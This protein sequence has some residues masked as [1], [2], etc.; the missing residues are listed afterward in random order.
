MIQL[1]KLA[2]QY[3]QK[4]YSMLDNEDFS[5]DYIDEQLSDLTDEIKVK[6]KNVGAFILNL[7][8]EHD[9]TAEAAKRMKLRADSLKKTHDSLVNYLIDNIVKTDIKEIK[10]DEF[11]IKLADCPESLVVSDE[12][13][14]PDIYLNAKIVKTLDKKAIKEAISSGENI[15]GCYIEKNKRLIIK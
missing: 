11:L 6:I 7:K 14:I 3:Q 2:N 15:P 9:A 5:L 12:R 10:C 8:A 1:Y 13:M 4:L